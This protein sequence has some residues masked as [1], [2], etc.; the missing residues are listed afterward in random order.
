MDRL[1]A[2]PASAAAQTV[3]S[4]GGIIQTG[5]TT[6]ISQAQVDEGPAGRLQT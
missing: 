5:P 4:V 1:W 2:I 6:L 3:F